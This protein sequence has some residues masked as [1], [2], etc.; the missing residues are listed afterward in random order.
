MSQQKKTDGTEIMPIFSADYTAITARIR[1]WIYERTD[2]W[3][4]FVVL[5]MLSP[6]ELLNSVME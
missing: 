2:M 1:R 5:L 3:F 4:L 6:Q